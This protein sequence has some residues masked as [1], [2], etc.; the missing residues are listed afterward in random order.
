MMFTLA[1]VDVILELCFL[2]WFVANDMSIPER[3][4]RF[5]LLIYLTSK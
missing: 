3:D 5:K 4:L 2:F 1:T